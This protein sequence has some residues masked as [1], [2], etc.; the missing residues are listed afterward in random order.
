MKDCSALSDI[1]KGEIDLLISDGLT[2]SPEEIVRI[3]ALA[4]NI[5]SPDARLALS[6]GFPVPVGGVTLWP[7]TLEAYD[8]LC[9][10][11]EHCDTV[12]DENFLTAYAMAHCY[13]GPLPYRGCD[14]IKIARSWARRLRCRAAELIEAMSQIIQQEENFAGV[15]DENAVSVGM[16]DLSASIAAMTGQPT[17][18]IERGMSMN[19]ALRILHYT[20]QAQE[21]IEGKGGRGS[22]YIRAEQAM[23]LYIND[24]RS[25]HG[26]A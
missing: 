10:N 7:M 1:A 14:S 13:D 19:H 24:L 17:E 8:W 12:K 9:R 22:A 6:R 21:R 20:M 4:W 15:E 11:L 26:K 16:G 18:S 5:E 23:G 3:N 25:K 2:L